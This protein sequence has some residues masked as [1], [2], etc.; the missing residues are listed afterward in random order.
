MNRDTFSTIIGTDPSSSEADVLPVFVLK[1]IT[2]GGAGAMFSL[3]WTQSSTILV[4]QSVACGVR[5]Q[6]PKVSRRHAAFS[7]EGSRVR[8]V[9]QGSSNGTFV[10]GVQVTEA[11]LRGG[12]TVTVGDTGIKLLRMGDAHNTMRQESES[13]GRV[14]GRSAEMQRV[15]VFGSRLATTTLPVV[16]EGETGTGKELFAEALH[17]ASARSQGPFFT[18]AGA[19]G[20]SHIDELLEDDGIFAQSVDGTLVLDEP[21]ELSLAAQ[22]RLLL[23]LARYGDRVRVITTTK[24]DLDREAQAGRLREDLMFRLGGGRIDLPPLRRRHGDISLLASHFWRIGGGS[25]EPPSALLAQL[26]DYHWPGNVREF[27]HAVERAVAF[28]DDYKLALASKLAATA[29]P[30]NGDLMSR[31]LTMDVSL[32][33]GRSLLVADYERRYVDM[34]LKQHGGN[35]TR[36]AA[37]S[38][39]TRRYFHMLRAKLR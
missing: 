37:A 14:L 19:N 27:R 32:Q 6:D 3:D 16:I 30:A 18:F 26:H 28:G 23:M 36:A 2:G 12:E 1:V 38:G 35:M 31:L 20:Q 10:N 5:L 9:D 21:A 34:A 29:E 39:L 15:F 25:G 17:E 22:S 8:V 4:G 11:L 33:Q 24:R 13:F 7:P